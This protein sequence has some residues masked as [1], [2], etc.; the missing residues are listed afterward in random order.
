MPQIFGFAAAA[1]I[2]ILQKYQSIS[3]PVLNEA[4]ANVLVSPSIRT[5][6]AAWSG[7][8]PLFAIA[9]VGLSTFI[10]P[11]YINRP[12]EFYKPHTPTLDLEYAPASPFDVVI[13][14]PQYVNPPL[15][16][17]KN[18]LQDLPQFAAMRPRIIVYS[19][20]PETNTTIPPDVEIRHASLIGGP[21]GTYIHHVLRYRDDLA[22]QTLFIPASALDS[23][24]LLPRIQAFLSRRTGMLNL[25]PQ[26]ICL[27]SN[28]KDTYNW[29]DDWKAVPEYY[30]KIYNPT[31]DPI[32]AFATTPA[33]LS[34]ESTFIASARRLRAIPV[35]VLHKLQSGLN[36]TA[37]F[38]RD[39]DGI[40]PHIEFGD[41]VERL[42][43][44]LLQC[45]DMEVGRKCPS[46][47]SRWRTGGAIGDCQCFDEL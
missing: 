21:S 4:L 31:E 26:S 34:H 47:Y 46:I 16:T 17:F 9:G 42:W 1:V 36:G 35:G 10:L 2:L 41:T 11:L 39:R 37:G 5:I 27:V 13:S 25:G 40:P 45:S 18:S 32:G 12:D 33:L 6:T 38:V 19:G 20:D 44:I 14:T 23:E 28:C 15:N 30:S 22:A 24:Y 43:S 3:S 7:L 29:R 8:V